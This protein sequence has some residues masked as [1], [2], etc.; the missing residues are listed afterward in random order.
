MKK[1]V[2]VIQRGKYRSP[3]IIVTLQL[4]DEI[5]VGGKASEDGAV[6]RSELVVDN[7]RG[8]GEGQEHGRQ[9][10]QDLGLRESC[11]DGMLMKMTYRHLKQ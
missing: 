5:L 10:I 1:S 2:K 6:A 8:D 7:L 3:L 11:V 9:H 4:Y